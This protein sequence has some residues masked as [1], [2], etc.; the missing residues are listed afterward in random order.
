VKHAVRS[1]RREHGVYVIDDAFQCRYLI[2]AG[3]T[4]VRSTGRCFAQPTA[5]ERPARP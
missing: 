2:G 3:G 4:V 1:I 5:R